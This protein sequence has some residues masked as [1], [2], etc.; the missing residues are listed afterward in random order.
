MIFLLFCYTTG[1][2][3]EYSILGIVQGVFEWLPVSSEGIIVLVRT[4]FFANTSLIDTIHLALFLHLGTVLA[5]LVYFRKDIQ[6]LLYSLF[7]F[8]TASLEDKKTISFIFISTL[9]TGVIGILL[10]L[11][12]KENEILIDS[13]TTL[14]TLGIGVLL[15]I[16]GVLLSLEKYLISERE[17]SDITHLDSILLGFVQAMAALPGLSRSGLT[18]SALLLRKFN[19]E[20]ALRLSFLMSIP[21]VLGGNILLNISNPLFS[22]ES[23]VALVFSFGFG[24]LTIH[25]L[26]KI[27]ERIHFGYFVL[28][29]GVLTIAAGLL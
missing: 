1:H 6:R 17:V 10:S 25:G 13:Y 18:V 2:M 8:K 11:F 19:K 12:I 3:L 7:Q 21:V 22:P 16:T 28:L 24:L 26:L 9:I 27:A 23:F 5:A 4:H 14:I 29:F 15:L 20:D